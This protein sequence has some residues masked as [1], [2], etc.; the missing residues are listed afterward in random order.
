M[1]QK[2]YLTPN[3]VAELLMVSPITIRQWAQK[4]L[5]HA[6]TTA[7]GHRRFKFSDVKSFA[8]QRG[9]TLNTVEFEKRILIVDSSTSQRQ[10]LAAN[11]KSTDAEVEIEQAED[12]FDAGVK[13]MTFKPTQIFINLDAPDLVGYDI[14]RYIK[15]EPDLKA[16]DIVA[17][18]SEQV[19]EKVKLAESAGANRCLI[20]PIDEAQLEACL[21]MG[22]PLSTGQLA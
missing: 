4:G 15:Q 3:E 18:L 9:L 5:I 11:I 10:Q 14:C 8:R 22:T 17:V 12:G 13:L 7:G 20:L 6:V 1:K 21:G 2:S 16:I 19:A